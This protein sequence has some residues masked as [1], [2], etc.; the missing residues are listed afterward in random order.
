MFYLLQQCS[1]VKAFTL[2]ILSMKCLQFKCPSIYLD[3]VRSVAFSIIHLS[4]VAQKLDTEEYSL[5]A[6]EKRP[7]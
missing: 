4:T 2:L 1:R 6:E 5:G 3:K 7:S